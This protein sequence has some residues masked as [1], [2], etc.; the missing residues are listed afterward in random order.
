MDAP[1]RKAKGERKYCDRDIQLGR[2]EALQRKAAR[3]EHL[4]ADRNGSRRYQTYRR[5]AQS[6]E[7][8][9]YDAAAA[10]FVIDA[11]NYEDNYYAR[12]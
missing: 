8:S 11:C 3:K 5:G 9:L 10:E 2:G 6:A 4:R 12:Q 7:A 1:Q